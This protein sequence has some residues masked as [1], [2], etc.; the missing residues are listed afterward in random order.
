MKM[1]MLIGGFLA[2]SIAVLYAAC[3]V[4]PEYD[5]YIEPAKPGDYFYDGNETNWIWVGE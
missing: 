3:A 4:K 5:G 1:K 2:V